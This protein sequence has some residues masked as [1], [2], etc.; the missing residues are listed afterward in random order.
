MSRGA[1]QTEKSAQLVRQR[2]LH[3]A[4]LQLGVRLP[5]GGWVGGLAM[6]K[7]SVMHHLNGSKE[8]RTH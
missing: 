3:L 6:A 7:G 8:V 1:L 4:H 2:A 5:N